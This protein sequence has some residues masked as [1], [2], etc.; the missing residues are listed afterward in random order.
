[1]NEGKEDTKAVLAILMPSLNDNFNT[2][3]HDGLWGWQ[4]L[5]LW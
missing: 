3:Q 2:L 1:M 5:G 4:E